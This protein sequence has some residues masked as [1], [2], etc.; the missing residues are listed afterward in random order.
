VYQTVA[1]RPSTFGNRARGLGLIELLV[2][3]AITAALLSAT[4][5]AVNAAISAY[6]VNATQSDT[7]HRTRISLER[8]STYVRT[9]TAHAPFTPGLATQ[10]SHGTTVTDTGISLFDT[11][12]VELSFHYDA[13]AGQLIVTENGTDHVLL[14]GVQRFTVSMEPM[15]SA[16]SIK[17]GGGFDQLRRATFTLTVSFANAEAGAKQ[18]DTAETIT[19]STAVV[20][21]KNI[22]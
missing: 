9:S 1:P 7:L 3:L 15:R 17:A 5:F 22:W 6:S 10:F 16:A 12:D 20:P 8:L 11:N 2:T 14:R 4:A 13:D 21:R 19:L 18:T